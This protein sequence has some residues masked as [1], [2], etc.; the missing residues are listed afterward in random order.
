[1][2][3]SLCESCEKMREVRTARSRFLLCELALVDT[4]YLSE[5]ATKNQ[6]ARASRHGEFGLPLTFPQPFDLHILLVDFNDRGEKGPLVDL[7]RRL[8]TAF[9]SRLAACD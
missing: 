1:M 9:K 3:R 4:D 8:A 5:M 7:T 6:V 2:G